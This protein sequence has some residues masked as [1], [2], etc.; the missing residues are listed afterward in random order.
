M[1]A[2]ARLRKHLTFAN[3]ASGLA[4]FIALATGGA[5]AANTIYPQGVGLL[6]AT[7]AATLHSPSGLNKQGSEFRGRL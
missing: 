4:L 7:G 1:P 5:Y 2:W 6:A 3:V